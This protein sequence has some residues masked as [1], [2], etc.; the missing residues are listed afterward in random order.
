MTGIAKYGG[1]K[2]VLENILQ[3]QIARDLNIENT[4]IDPKFLGNKLKKNSLKENIPRY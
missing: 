2:E 3:M 1:I 4:K